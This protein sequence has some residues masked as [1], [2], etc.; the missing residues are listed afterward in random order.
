MA[1]YH[2]E[3]AYAATEGTDGWNAPAAPPFGLALR[4]TIT[5]LIFGTCFESFGSFGEKLRCRRGK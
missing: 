1:G 2:V 3:Y 4:A 5:M